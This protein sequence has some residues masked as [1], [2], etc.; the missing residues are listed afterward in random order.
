[1]DVEVFGIQ[2]AFARLKEV[3]FC[4]EEGDETSVQGFVTGGEG[5]IEIR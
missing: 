2:P 5:C 4:F 3:E 1:M